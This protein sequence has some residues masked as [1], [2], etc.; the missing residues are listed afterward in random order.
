VSRSRVGLQN[1]AG[2]DGVAQRYQ[3]RSTNVRGRVAA[4]MSRARALKGSVLKTQPLDERRDHN[5]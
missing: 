5:D 4:T 3:N 1:A 2:N